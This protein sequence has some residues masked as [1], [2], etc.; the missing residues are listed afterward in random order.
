MQH[1]K[2][3]KQQKLQEKMQLIEKKLKKNTREEMNTKSL[4]TNCNCHIIS[5]DINSCYH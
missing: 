5:W 1:K 3:N 2:K 4:P